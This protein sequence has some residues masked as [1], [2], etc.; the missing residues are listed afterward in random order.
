MV[1][2][3]IALKIRPQHLEK[4][5][6]LY[7]RQSTHNGLI[8]NIVG[9]RRQREEILALALQYGWSR[10]KII[11]VDCDQAVSGS[12]TDK[13]YGYMEMLQSIADGKV[14]AVFSLESARLGRDSADWHYLIKACLLTGTLIIDAEG[15]YDASDS[16]DSTLMK[17]KA[18]MSE[19]ELRWI[20]DR[21]Q[22]A[23]LELAK[24]GQLRNLRPAGFVYS[25]DKKV[26][27]DPDLAVQGAIQT[28]F[29]VFK[30]V[31]TAHGVVRHFNQHSLKFPIVVRSGPR[32][33]ECDWAPL[34]G[35][36]VCL[37]LHNPTYAGA[38]VYGRNS[39]KRKLVQVAGGMPQVKK[40]QIRLPPEEWR[41]VIQDAHPG[42]IT[43]SQFLENQERLRNN[44]YRQVKGSCGA[45]RVGSALLQGLAVCGKCGH[46]MSPS[47]SKKQAVATYL[48][49]DA[50]KHFARSLCQYM[51]GA[52]IEAAIVKA[53]FDAVSPTQ[54]T[55][56]LD[57]LKRLEMESGRRS[58]QWDIRT[59]RANDALIKAK[60]R[61][62][63]V[64]YKNKSA[65]D[66]AQEEL[67]KRESELTKLKLDYEGA[68]DHPI[69]KV[70]ATE[71]RLV[72]SLTKDLPRVW[73]ASS[74]D[75]VTKKNLL[76]CLI[77][78]V[79]LIRNGSRVSIGIRWKT[80]ACTE[81]VVDLPS[82]VPKKRMSP[83][84]VPRIKQ[85]AVDHTNPQIADALNAAGLR[86]GQGRLFTEKRVKR[87]RERYRI[88]SPDV[89]WRARRHDGTYGIRMVA[90][91]LE[92]HPQTVRNCCRK[93]RFPA[94][95]TASAGW[96]VFISKEEIERLTVPVRSRSRSRVS[97]KVLALLSEHAKSPRD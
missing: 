70:T 86:N 76:R 85:L 18:L 96:G 40:H 46:R 82:P 78:D 5:A 97:E 32:A 27:L 90:Q 64:D 41:F 7:S 73:A 93:G 28:L 26:I 52:A 43:W 42:Y 1:P 33:G 63:F 75:F 71:V 91:L 36:R 58:L 80:F 89:E 6:W 14:G 45:A 92:L 72:R 15:V 22:G 11:V 79:T 30:R 47:Y 94:I 67:K 60:E 20:T 19:M 38:Y 16:N 68:R 83:E 88:T 54:I 4:E 74:N 50:Q 12:S 66:C 95:R 8:H 65:F 10:N 3:N 77:N 17:V 35:V 37:I 56:S 53:L 21:L 61:M 9:G 87:L 34:S 62:L 81:M 48:C 69:T 59:K 29:S 39:I 31:G 2:Q 24:K 23:K 57:T 25:K 55:V 84:L 44:Q 51:P 13:R 49:R